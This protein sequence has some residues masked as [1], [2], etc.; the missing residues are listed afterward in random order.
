MAEFLEKYLEA[1][2]SQ[3]FVIDYKYNEER[4]GFQNEHTHE[5]IVAY[6]GRRY[7]RTGASESRIYAPP[8]SHDFSLFTPVEITEG[9]YKKLSAGQ[10]CSDTP[11]ALETLKKRK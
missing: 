9:E 4:S 7:V 2:L 11:E 8:G 10:T 6:D 5:T 1:G 3:I